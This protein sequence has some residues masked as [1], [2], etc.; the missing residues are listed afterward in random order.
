MWHFIM[1]IYKILT[2]RCGDGARLTSDALDN[3]LPWHDRIAVRMHM[4]VCR[5]CRYFKQH[6]LHVREVLTQVAQGKG[7]DSNHQLIKL[8]DEAKKRLREK[9]RDRMA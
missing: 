9:M 3:R 4:L 1:R 8:S 7:Q 5:P 2:L 6:L